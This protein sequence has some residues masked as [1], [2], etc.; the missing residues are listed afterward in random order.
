[1]AHAQFMC[2]RSIQ[3]PEPSPS[4]HALMASCPSWSHITTNPDEPYSQQMM[5]IPN[6]DLMRLFTLSQ[7]LPLDGEITPVMALNMIRSHPR[8]R[9]MTLE[10][11]EAVTA[12]LASKSRCYG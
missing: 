12:D 6:S 2:V 9:E 11:F 3:E 10:N 4:G 7:N 8:Y 5:S 1:M